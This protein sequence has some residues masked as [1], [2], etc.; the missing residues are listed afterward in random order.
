MVGLHSFRGINAFRTTVRPIKKPEDYDI[1]KF[2]VEDTEYTPYYEVYEIFK[3]ITGV[4][5]RSAGI[6]H[7]PFV[8]MLIDW[9][10]PQ[11]LYVDMVRRPDKV[12]GLYEA[13]VK[14]HE[15]LYPIVLN[16]PADVVSYGDHVDEV[17]IPPPIFEKY[18]LPIQNK[19]ALMAHAA[20]KHVTIHMDGR[21]NGLKHLISKLEV[22][23]ING[24]TP[25]PSGNLPI[26]EAL[27]IWPDK[28]L[29]IN[30]DNSQYLY[31]PDAVKKSLL[32]LLREVIPGDRVTISPS[33]EHWV[34]P[35]CLKVF[36]DIMEKATLPLTHEKIDEIERSV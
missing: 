30:F 32:S 25:P 21:V 14:N 36:A 16:A 28:I 24:L 35:E 26:R 34:P 11:R 1:V 2:I 31:G 27:D 7:S 3:E 6:G 20:G 5:S 23:S 15:E 17:L 13:L 12:Q 29:T 19:F 33:T 22:D 8:S 10:G 9:A 18:V 4:Y